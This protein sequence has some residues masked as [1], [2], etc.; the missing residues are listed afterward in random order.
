MI[1]CCECIYLG[2]LI[3]NRHY[4]QIVLRPA[5]IE[6]RIAMKERYNKFLGYLHMCKLPGDHKFVLVSEG[7][8][9]GIK[10]PSRK[11]EFLIQRNELMDREFI[12][13]GPDAIDRRYKYVY[14]EGE[15]INYAI[16]RRSPACFCKTFEKLDQELDEVQ[17]EIDAADE[18][19]A[20]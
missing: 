7:C 2:E 10:K 5:S 13:P 15:K 17:D 9:E 6:K 16:C 12:C 3:T 8:D 11:E 19:F 4:T 20:V 14:H 1:K 18:D